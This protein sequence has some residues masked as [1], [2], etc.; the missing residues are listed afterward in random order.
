MPV[1]GLKNW[2]NE[3][4]ETRNVLSFKAAIDNMDFFFLLF[5][6]SDMVMVDGYADGSNKNFLAIVVVVVFNAYEEGFSDMS[7]CSMKSWTGQCSEAFFF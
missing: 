2:R 7:T 6:G 1:V 3:S 5:C 4:W